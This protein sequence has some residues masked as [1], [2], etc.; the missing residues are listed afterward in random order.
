MRG[1]RRDE[2]REERRGERRGKGEGRGEE[3]IGER[4]EEIVYNTDQRDRRRGRTAPLYFALTK[5]ITKLFAHITLLHS[6]FLIPI[7]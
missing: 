7:R 6:C 4:G 5:L 1:E 2:R 3:R